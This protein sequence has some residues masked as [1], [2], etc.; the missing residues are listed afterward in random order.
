MNTVFDKKYDMYMESFGGKLKRGL[1][2]IGKYG[3]IGAVAANAAFGSPS[4]DRPIDWDNIEN[5]PEVAPAAI[6]SADDFKKDPDAYL[7]KQM[8][9]QKDQDAKTFDT[10]K[11]DRKLKDMKKHKIGLRKAPSGFSKSVDPDAP[12]DWDSL[13]DDE[14][15][16]TTTKKDTL[17][18]IQDGTYSSKYA[19][20]EAYKFKLKQWYKKNATQ[21]NSKE[22][23][24]QARDAFKKA[25]LELGI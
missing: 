12:F 16:N 7:K 6:G 13:T 4:Y 5:D 9:Q 17:K 18:D 8:N 23:Q 19:Q 10:T 24:K 3:A 21:E 2:K 20:L 11:M 25:K 1:K 14:E 15:E 22:L